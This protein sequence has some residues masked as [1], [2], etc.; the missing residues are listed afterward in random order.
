M[1]N[2]LTVEQI[3]DRE[4]KKS[5]INQE[6]CYQEGLARGYSRGGIQNERQD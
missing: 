5:T 3:L 1:K 4:L 6:S 2:E